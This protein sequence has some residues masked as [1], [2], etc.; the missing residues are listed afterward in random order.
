M[1][2][3]FAYILEDI[4]FTLRRTCAR[5]FKGEYNPTSYFLHAGM[6]VTL[7]SQDYLVDPGN[8]QCALRAPIPVDFSL[9]GTQH[10]EHHPHEKFI[11]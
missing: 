11:F 7:D 8:G 1:N 6:I 10:I 3:L 4:G 2:G 5:P 9:R